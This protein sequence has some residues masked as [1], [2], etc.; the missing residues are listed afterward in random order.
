[1]PLR[2]EFPDKLDWDLL[3][4]F[5]IIAD[6]KSISRAALRLRR[7]QSAVSHSLK[8]LETQLG[9]RLIDRS[10]RN[11]QL[12]SEG[13]ALLESATAVYREIV[14]LGNTLNKEGTDISGT[15]RLL[16]VSRIVSDV[17]D[18]ALATFRLR[19]P[20]AKISVEVLLSSETIKRIEQDVAVL[21]LAICR[22]D[23]KNI[24]RVELIPE[25]YSLYCGKHHP[26]FE[27]KAIKMENLLTQNFVSFISEQFGDALSPLAIFRDTQQFKGE[28]IASSNNFDEIKRLLYAGY[29][30]GCLADNT[31]EQDVKNG[32]LRKIP[33]DLPIANIPVNLVWG[34]NRKLKP[35]E[36][37][38]I[39]VLFDAFGIEQ[40]IPAQ[41]PAEKAAE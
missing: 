8:R 6:E 15:L 10:Y 31:V 30:I 19:H 9:V 18:D 20:Q 17:F 14:R 22:E 4:S 13:L 24:N 32:F 37:A 39:E 33:P 16:V 35:V 12:T 27:Q 11:F 36:L 28:I 3:Q 34:R 26:L 41:Q 29:G 21:G 25:W 2:G 23:T 40:E 7:T 5:R 38:F 1:M